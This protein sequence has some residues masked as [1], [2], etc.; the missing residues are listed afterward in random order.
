MRAPLGA[1]LHEGVEA[2][3]HQHHREYDAG[4]SSVTRWPTLHS[5]GFQE[6]RPHTEQYT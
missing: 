1:E 3:H 6:Q 2:R 5:L 4:Q